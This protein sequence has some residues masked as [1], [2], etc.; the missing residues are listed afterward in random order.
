LS[1][2]ALIDRSPL[3]KFIFYPRKF[4]LPPPAY[5]FDMAFPVE[6]G[7][8]ISCRFFDG[9]GDLPWILYFHGNGEIVSDYNSISEL[10]RQYG[11]SL[12]VADYR[13]YGTS[14]GRPTLTSLVQDARIL[15]RGVRRELTGRGFPGDLVVMGRSLGSVSALELAHDRP[16]GL[17]G[18]ILESGFISVVKLLEHLGL[19]LPAD[20]RSFDQESCRKVK[21]IKLPALVIHG[22]RDRLVPFSQGRE[23]YHCLG[24]SRK[25]LVD[26]PGADHNDIIFR[27]TERYFQA[28]H[29]FVHSLGKNS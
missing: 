20:L 26:I 24:S 18:L 16:E 10:Y 5:A 4:Y 7:V 8:S 28:V 29:R 15:Y 19:P 23:L 17:R 3:L 11:L 22:T 27:D 25:E 12:V 9:G 6:E 2:Y 1:G 21:E 14:G 13:G